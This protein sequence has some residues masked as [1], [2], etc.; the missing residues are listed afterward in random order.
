MV[1]QATLSNDIPVYKQTE[2]SNNSSGLPVTADKLCAL[3]YIL[4][5]VI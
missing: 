3:Y 5:P 1:L 4:T 2:W